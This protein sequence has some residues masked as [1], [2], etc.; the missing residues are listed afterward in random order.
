PSVDFYKGPCIEPGG[1]MDPSQILASTILDAVL[2]LEKSPRG[3]GVILIEQETWDAMPIES[4]P[5]E[6]GAIATAVA[7]GH[8]VVE[9]AGNGG[10][11]LD[12]ATGYTLDA[13]GD[14]VARS[15]D[16]TV[17]GPTSGAI[18]VA[19]GRSGVGGSTL[20]DRSATSNF[21]N[22]VDCC[23]WGDSIAALTVTRD[24]S[25][26]P[27]LID[28]TTGFGGTSGAS[29]MIAGA[30]VLMQH[31]RAEAKNA[32][33]TPSAIRDLLKIGTPGQG[34]LT[35]KMMP[36]LADST[37]RDKIERSGE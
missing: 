23:A 26:D 15:L 5:L 31:L 2:Q 12:S 33:L 37:L 29:A 3:T 28:D 13:N 16:P 4:Q 11:S 20:G 14:W 24:A 30:V 22:L 17:P 9:P 1:T 8:I 19:G 18:V 25:G 6:F 27:F 34:D 7:A 10:Q 35:G 36:N 21:G 32:Q